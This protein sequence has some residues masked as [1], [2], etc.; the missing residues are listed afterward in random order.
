MKRDGATGRLVRTTGCYVD[1]KGYLTVTCGPQRGQ[2]LHRL[3]ASSM[4]GR[5]LRKDEDVH[6]RNGDKLDN[7]P[8]NLEIMGHRQH[9]WITA[10]QH[11]WMKTLDIRGKVEWD[12]Y[13][14]EV[15]LRV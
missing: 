8:E 13:F 6:H 5:P 9:G 4:L 12:K 14:D 15:G 7:R 3:V 11:F 2:R 10:K 1:S